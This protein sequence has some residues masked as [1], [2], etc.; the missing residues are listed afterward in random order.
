MSN[1]IRTGKNKVTIIGELVAFENVRKGQTKAGKDYI[2]GEIIV[3]TTINEVENDHKVKF[4]SQ[5][6]NSK[7]E[8]SKAYQGFETAIKEQKTIKDHE[9]GDVVQITA[10]IK[11]NAYVS[12]EDGE[13]RVF[14]ELSANFA[15]RRV[16]EGTE[17][18]AIMEV[19]GMVLMMD[20]E[21]DQ[22]EKP[23]GRM[24]LSVAVV[25]YGGELAIV[26]GFAEAELAQAF[27]GMYRP[28]KSGVFYFDLV[29]RNVQTEKKVQLGFGKATT[30]TTDYVKVERILTGGSM[31]LERDTAYKSDEIN[32][33]MNLRRAKHEALKEE[34]ANEK[35][36]LG[37]GTATTTSNDA[38]AGM[39]MAASNDNPFSA[40]M[41]F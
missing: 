13:V 8:P 32:Q 21:L 40:N 38:F 41:P 9:K 35:P 7:G 20:K 36:N 28:E 30:T 3:R 19:E 15:P 10:S 33:L 37:F 27:K 23:T 11:E 16:K 17:H 26:D 29:A 22:N 25:N 4:F 34:K 2:G 6:T 39:N 5:A 1:N 31:P 24:K 18:V 12:K 14:N